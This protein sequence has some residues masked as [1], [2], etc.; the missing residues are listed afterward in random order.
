MELFG[1]AIGGVAMF[2][3][4]IMS[5]VAIILI[6]RSRLVSSGDVTIHI[7]DDPDK[8]KKTIGPSW[9]LSHAC[10]FRIITISNN[11]LKNSFI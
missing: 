5:L 6:A 8:S 7:N 11:N 2:T 9:H 10:K 4:I 3:L 1:T